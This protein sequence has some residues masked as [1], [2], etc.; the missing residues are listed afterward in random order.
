MRDRVM[1]TELCSRKPTVRN[2]N[3][4]YFY[5]VFDPISALPCL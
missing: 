3:K 1:A 2:I 4:Y 5:N